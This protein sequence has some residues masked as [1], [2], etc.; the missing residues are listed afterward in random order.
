MKK[1]VLW[2]FLFIPY[3]GI[4]AQEISSQE[5]TMK[6]KEINQIKLSEEALY[7]EVIELATDDYEAVSLAQ[8]KSINKLQAS[9]IEACAQKMNMSKEAVK[10]IFDVIDDKCQNVVIKKGDMLRVFSYIA[11]DAIGLSR[12]KAK[13][14]DIEEYLGNDEVK[15][16]EAKLI[17]QVT[18]KPEPKPEPKVEPKVEVVSEVKVEPKVEKKV[19]VKPEP[20]V[21]PKPEIKPEPKPEPKVEPKPEPAPAPAPVVAPASEVVVP[22][23][24]QTMH[25]KGNM[26]DLMRYLNQEKRYQR[27]MFGNFN[28]MQYPSKCYVVIIDKSTRNIVSILDKGENERMNFITKQMDRY[29]NYRGG[30]YAAIFVQEY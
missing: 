30:N 3:M 29:S 13:K 8:Q 11:K 4:Q 23:L 18:P 20:K 6:K 16:K 27:L 1:N 9:V 14:E 26:N 7:A 19:E 28:S 21:E 25:A 17:A 5:E 2:A 24:C 15:D 22:A 12:R 10:E